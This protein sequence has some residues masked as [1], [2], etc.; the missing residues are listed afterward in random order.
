MNEDMK[1]VLLREKLEKQL[2]KNPKFYKLKTE[3]LLLVGYGYVVWFVALFLALFGF[4][5]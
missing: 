4:L 5:V 2:V 3:F 1:H